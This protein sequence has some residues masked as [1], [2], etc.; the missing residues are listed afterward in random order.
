MPEMHLRQPGYTYS[1][2]GPFTK[3]KERIQKFEEARDSQY[4]YQN[5]LDQACFQHEQPLSKY[6]LIKHLILLKIRNMM[7]IKEVLL[8][9]LIHFLIKNFWQQYEK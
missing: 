4:I 7:D 2:C 3:H 6:C 9:W 5:N 1:A 8:Q